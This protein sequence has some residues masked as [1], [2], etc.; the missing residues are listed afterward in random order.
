ML[1]PEAAGVLVPA[2]ELE[3]LEAG[4]V[5][6]RAPVTGTTGVPEGAAAGVPVAALVA[7]GA[8]VPDGAL[9]LT[10]A[11]VPT[12]EPVAAL[13]P[14]GVVVPAPVLGT[15]AEGVVPLGAGVLAAQAERT[16]ANT[17]SAENAI[18]FFI[19]PPFLN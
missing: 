15:T 9:V 10:G 17:T 14:A 2:A 12:G 5:G 18:L 13:V 3:E 4:L 11:L 1:V 8:E 7:A 16:K 6:Q 19:D